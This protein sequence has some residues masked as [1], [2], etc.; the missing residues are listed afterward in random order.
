M[1]K[2]LLRSVTIFFLLMMLALVQQN[3]VGHSHAN[4]T[5]TFKGEFIGES[6]YLDGYKIVLYNNETRQSDS[7]VIIHGK[8]EIRCEFLRPT[9]YLLYSTYELKKKGGFQPLAILVDTTCTVRIEASKEQFNSSKVAG[10]AP[11]KVLNDFLNQLADKLTAIAE[12]DRELGIIKAKNSRYPLQPYLL[13]LY[14]SI[15]TNNGS[16]L[17]SGFIL[18]RYTTYFDEDTKHRLYEKLTTKG[19]SFSYAQAFFQK[20]VA[21]RNAVAGKQGAS[22][23]LPDSG[24]VLVTSDSFRGKFV[25]L[26]FWLSNCL[27]CHAENQILRRIWETYQNKGL[28]IISV[29]MDYLKDDWLAYLRKEKL[30]WVHLYE[31]DRTRSVARLKYGVSDFPASFLLDPS[32]TIIGSKLNAAAIEEWLG[33]YFKNGSL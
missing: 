4:Q 16:S 5:I 32:G 11:N 24:G 19:K 30:P 12:S 6:K 33:A 29:S 14:D 13:P 26:D 8:F 3:A 7:A 27:K 25:V 15:L 20:L 10:A 1:R 9:R 2:N 22:F 21:Q 28:V 31:T 17:A 18:D 23:E